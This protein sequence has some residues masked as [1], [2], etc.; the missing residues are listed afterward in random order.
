MVH[1]AVALQWAQATEERT[2]STS[3]LLSDDKGEVKPLSSISAPQMG[4]VKL[5]LK[6]MYVFIYLFGRDP[7]EVWSAV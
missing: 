3:A 5:D 2:S 6:C 4:L 1:T 7:S